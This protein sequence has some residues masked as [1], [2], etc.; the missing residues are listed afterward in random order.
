[1]KMTFRW[2][3]TDDPVSL[4]YIKQIPNITGIVSAVYDIPVGEVWPIEKIEKLK[5]EVNLV[6]LE[7]E[8]IES[9]PVHEDIKLKRNDYQRYIDN[10]KQ[11]IR[12]LAK[13]GIKCIRTYQSV[14]LNVFVIILCLFLIGLDLLLI[15]N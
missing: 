2:Y 7:L 1:M 6:G 3:G 10:Y 13:C 9:V 5:A 4:E 8:V 12:N 14:G 15:I 11:T